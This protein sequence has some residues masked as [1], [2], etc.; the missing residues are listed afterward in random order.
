MSDK[1]YQNEMDR[2]MLLN[3]Q[4]QKMAHI[5]LHKKEALVE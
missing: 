5:K 4:I 2:E 1:Y 3:I